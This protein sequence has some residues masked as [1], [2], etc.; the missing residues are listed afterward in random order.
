MLN[1]QISAQ[2]SKIWNIPDIFGTVRLN[3]KSWTRQGFEKICFNFEIIENP[4]KQ[5]L[6][7]FL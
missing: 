2:K 4:D 3:Q 5:N 7:K 1:C 6:C